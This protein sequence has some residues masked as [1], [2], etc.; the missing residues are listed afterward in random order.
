MRSS[1]WSSDLCSADLSFGQTVIQNGAFA[2]GGTVVMLPR[3]EAQAALGLMLKEKVTFFAGVPTMYWGLL[4]AL[5]EGVDVSAIAENLRIAA[6][7]GSALPGEV[8][9]NFKERF[10]VTI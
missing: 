5:G 6:A 8:H 4:G 7:G 10:G 2:F 9:K 3:F 1:Y